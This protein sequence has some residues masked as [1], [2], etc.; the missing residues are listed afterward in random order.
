MPNAPVVPIMR[1]SAKP[2]VPRTEFE[3]SQHLPGNTQFG[4]E[5]GSKRRIPKALPEAL[6]RLIAAAKTAIADVEAE[7]PA[8]AELES[9]R[10]FTQALDG[11]E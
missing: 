1:N 8:V 9:W 2:K 3:L 11:I 10:Q 6:E 5:G 4:G 7:H